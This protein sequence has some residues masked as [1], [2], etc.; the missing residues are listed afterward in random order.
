MVKF[1]E[2]FYST[3]RLDKDVQP[4]TPGS[5]GETWLF[6]PGSDKSTRL[7]SPNSDKGSPLDVMKLHMALERER[8]RD[9]GENGAGATEGHDP[10]V[11]SWPRMLEGMMKMVKQDRQAGLARSMA[12]DTRNMIAHQFVLEALSDKRWPTR[13]QEQGIPVNRQTLD[14]FYTNLFKNRSAS[15]WESNEAIRNFNETVRQL[16]YNYLE[17]KESGH[18]GGITCEYLESRDAY[19]SRNITLVDP[20]GNSHVFDKGQSSSMIAEYYLKGALSTEEVERLIRGVQVDGWNCVT[21]F[22]CFEKEHYYTDGGNPIFVFTNVHRH[23]T[24]YTVDEQ[25][26]LY[27]EHP[28]IEAP[29]P[30]YNCFADFFLNNREVCIPAVGDQI[31]TIIRDHEYHEVPQ[32]D[33]KAI[34]YYS[35]EDYQ[36]LG[37]PKELWRRIPAHVGRVVFGEN[38]NA[39]LSESKPGEWG[40]LPSLDPYDPMMISVFGYPV[41]VCTDR[42]L[43]DLLHETPPANS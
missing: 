26:D 10:L 11:V 16:G 14:L 12:P 41:F 34:F 4:S 6:T 32:K 3:S 36:S 23:Y 22:K 28:P 5:S 7:S 13:L 27:P 40:R 43:G 31:Q 17:L 9:R 33:S 35:E 18:H 39:L 38:G 37:S 42:A 19:Y 29:T 25:V 30:Q 21:E 1:N 2:I 24:P 15:P 8:R 20:D